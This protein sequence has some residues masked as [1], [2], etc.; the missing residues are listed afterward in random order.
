MNR[1]TRT[2]AT[3]LLGRL[4]RDG[5]STGLSDAELA[6]RF[7]KTRDHEAFATLVM[8]HGPMVMAVCRGSLGDQGDA[9]DA[10]QATFL[11]LLKRLGSFPVGD[12]LGGWLHRV[13]KRVVRQAR[14]SE[15]R[16]R[17]RESVAILASRSSTD[18]EPER[19]EIIEWVRREI[20]VLPER[21]RV[22]IVLCDL[23]GLTRSEAAH[24]LGCPEGTIAARISRGRR[25]LHDRLQRRGVEPAM[26]ALAT[27]AAAWRTSL[28]AAIQTASAIG[29]GKPAT[30]T[31]IALAA[32]SLA[33][34]GAA[35][36][37]V[38]VTLLAAVCFTAGLIAAGRD[39]EPTKTPATAPNE[40]T[41]QLRAIPDPDDPK[42]AGHF[43]GQVIGPDDKP[44][45]GAKIF[46]VR[47][48]ATF[49]TSDPLRATS[50][51]NGQFA[52]DAPDMTYT[53]SDGLPARRQ[54]RLIATAEGY[55]LDSIRTWGK[56]SSSFRSH[57]D[58]VKGA[59]LILRPVRND[60][61]IHGQILNPDGKPLAG[62]E[63]RLIGLETPAYQ[64]FDAYLDK[65]KQSKN[66]VWMFDFR[67]IQIAPDVATQILTNDEGRFEI[68][69]L[70]N[71]RIATLKVTAP[72]MVD[73][74]LRV[75]TR[76][77]DDIVLQRDPDGFPVR[78]NLGANFT[79]KLK[80]GRSIIGV[81]RDRQT[82]EPIA[83]MWVGV[84][85][86]ESLGSRD[87]V[88]PVLTDAKG[89]FTLT[90][91]HPATKN[92]EI[93]AVSQPG[94]PY[95]MG[96]TFVYEEPAVIECVKGIPFRIKLADEKGLPV[97]G[98]VEYQ[99]IIPNPYL[100]TDLPGIRLDENHPVSVGATQVPGVYEGFVLPGPGAILVKGVDPRRYRPARVD[101]KAFFAPGKTDWT[102]QE[103]VSSY[104][105]VDTLNIGQG[106]TDQHDYDAILLVN[107]VL[108]LKPL[109]LAG[110]V[111]KFTK[112]L[113]EI[114]LSRASLMNLTA[115]LVEDKPRMVRLLDPEGKPV[116]GVDTQGLTYHPWD[117]EPRLRASTIPLTKLHPD[118]VRRIKFLKEDRGWI[119]LLL[120]KGD[121]DTPYTVTLQPWASITGR[122]VDANGRPMLPVGSPE[123]QAASLSIRLRLKVDGAGNP[124]FD[125]YQDLKIDGKG[126]F[127]V[128]RLVPGV[129]YDIMI[130]RPRSTGGMSMELNPLQPGAAIFMGDIRLQEIDAG[131]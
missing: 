45:A 99:P 75:M 81:V 105:T 58:P 101:P 89:Q 77:T 118:R 78:A 67:S 46:I 54:G 103:I 70:G 65:Y 86:V 92:P 131:R 122:I 36:L 95:L 127:R 47:Y 1:L 129:P 19:A 22:P 90:G 119:G 107:P 87:G 57:F 104:G 28:Q 76:D 102:P 6:S 33:A 12:S 88:R 37:K 125:E 10:F 42:L 85:V 2:S 24:L 71:D 29:A 121:A 38:A 100:E 106:W 35:K 128:D 26:L 110:N 64:T 15:N 63:V 69:G 113:S 112:R 117:A 91:I 55:A 16:R 83:G 52:I 130:F 60:V 25:R 11:I 13:A 56:T 39:Q 49:S 72:G 73:M 97:N 30:S 93:Q 14:L 84:N 123:N 62:A 3:P 43:E 17:K 32:R 116:V 20:S 41:K 66:E 115:T 27:P 9:D 31:A 8:R 48:N 124:V 23:Q 50:D 120:A 126:Q 59:P 80:A 51:A 111:E 7:I 21:Y 5:T 82:H 61:A 94:M 53:A 74:P 96:Q 79:I 108:E 34:I 40:P 68:K 4:F 109:E 114:P 98:R 44:L 18:H